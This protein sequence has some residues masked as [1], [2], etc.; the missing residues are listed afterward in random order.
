MK[1]RAGWL[2]IALGVA[3]GVL[4]V[5]SAGGGHASETIGVLLLPLLAVVAGAALL[6]RP[7]DG[8]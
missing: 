1:K 6:A 8:G 2:L 4:V 3:W 7:K 5:R